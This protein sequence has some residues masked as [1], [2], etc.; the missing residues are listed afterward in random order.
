M[1]FSPCFWIVGSAT[2]NW[3]TRFRITLSPWS[4]KE[5]RRSVITF[6]FS[7]SSI[8]PA[9][10]VLRPRV[11]LDEAGEHL[12]RLRERLRGGELD[13]DPRLPLAGDLG[14]DALLLERRPQVSRHAVEH[15][16]DPLLEVHAEDQVDPALEVQA[17]G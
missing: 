13:H 8:R 10:G 9:A 17:R 11:E 16:L 7:A 12:L 1:R 3:S 15:V 2:P 6:S 4:T 14:A 5:L